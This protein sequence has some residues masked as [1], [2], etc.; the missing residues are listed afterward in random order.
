MTET[1]IDPNTLLSEVG[2]KH[3]APMG[4]EFVLDDPMADVVL[5]KV[6]FVDGD[7]DMGGA[8]W[9]GGRD[10][11]PLYAAIGE[12]FQYF[13]RAETREKAK[14]AI[15]TAF[16]DL[17][18]KE[19]PE[20]L[21]NEDVLLDA[22]HW[23]Y[24][25]EYANEYEEHGGSFGGGVNIHD[26]VDRA[27]RE[28]LLPIMREYEAALVKEWGRPLIYIAMDLFGPE[29]TEEHLVDLVYYTMMVCHGH[30]ISLEDKY[31]D[32]LDDYQHKFG[33]PFKRRPFYTELDELRNLAHE[34]LETPDPCYALRRN[35]DGEIEESNFHSREAA[36]KFSDDHKPYYN[37]CSVVR[38]YDDDGQEQDALD[39]LTEKEEEAW[40]AEREQVRIA[41][42]GS[43]RWFISGWRAKIRSEREEAAAEEETE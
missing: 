26:V 20:S 41:P 40:E 21:L 15:L 19:D 3:G 11:Q 33:W 36:Q 31:S 13:Q 43:R 23:L 7:Y 2:G 34:L 30:G 25:L 35:P 17:K 27:P 38:V 8:Y 4:R 5:F 39:V 12:G 14:K 9:G 6:T 16:P 1:Y 32:A 22:G 18:I 24:S 28:K 37:G 42:D 10:S 29:P